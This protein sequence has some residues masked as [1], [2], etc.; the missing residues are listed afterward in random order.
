[1]NKEIRGIVSFSNFPFFITMAKK[2]RDNTKKTT[3]KPITYGFE[4]EYNSR[5]TAE[6]LLLSVKYLGEGL[7]PPGIE[8]KEALSQMTPEDAK[9]AKR[10][11]RKVFR[12]FKKTVA[13]DV[14]G[15]HWGEEGKTPTK[16]QKLRRKMFVEASYIMAMFDPTDD[17]SSS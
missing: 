5:Q 3:K 2:N 8:L 7:I 11:F 14:D 16:Y 6:Q 10:K 15:S 17:K 1:M 9:K 12:R 13:P 4:L